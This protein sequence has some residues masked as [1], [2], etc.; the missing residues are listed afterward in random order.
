M[1]ET[2][3]LQIDVPIHTWKKLRILKIKCDAKNWTEFMEKVAKD[4]KVI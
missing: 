3:K 4:F 1:S 2:K